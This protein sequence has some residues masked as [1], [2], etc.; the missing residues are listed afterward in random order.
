MLGEDGEA[1]RPA[2]VVA[3]IGNHEPVVVEPFHGIGLAQRVLDLAV[4]GN[5]AVLLGVDVFEGDA[6]GREMRN[7]LAACRVDD[8][9]MVVLLQGERDL[10]GS[11]K[12]T[13]SGSG[14]PAPR[15]RCR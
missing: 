1:A 13:N 2:L 4:E 5:R 8:H 15:Q 6:A 7:D 12:A 14:P 10:A 11:L 9:D 3:F